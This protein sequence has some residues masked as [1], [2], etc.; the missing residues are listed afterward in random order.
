M[1]RDIVG[2]ARSPIARGEDSRAPLSAIERPQGSLA[3]GG[4]IDLRTMVRVLRR[5]KLMLVLVVAVGLAGTQAWIMR[6]TPLYSAD[7]LLMIESRPSSIVTTDSA[8]QDAATG[9]VAVN[10]QIA[11]LRSRSLAA[12]VIEG[13]GLRED[14]EFAPGSEPRT[15]GLPM[16]LLNQALAWVR[17]LLPEQ[18]AASLPT[19]VNEPEETGESRE[20]RIR[21][22]LHDDFLGRL[23]VRSEDQSRLI[24]VS[25]LSADP[26]KAAAITNALLKTY[27]DSQLDAKTEGARQTATWLEARLGE[28]GAT[29]NDLERTV[30]Q[31]RTEAGLFMDDGQNVVPQRLGQLNA[32]LVRT[33]A[34]RA[35]LEARQL[36]IQKF[37]ETGRGLETLPEVISSPAVQSYRGRL[38]QLRGQLSELSD[39]YQDGNR[40]VAAVEAE[41][42]E[43]Q[44][45]IA[46]EMRTVLAG[47]ANELTYTGEQEKA[48]RRQLDEAGE[49]VARLNSASLAIGQLTTQLRANRDLYE[50]LLKRYT[51]TVALRD[52]QQPDARIISEAQVPIAPSFPNTTRALALASVASIAVALLFVIIAE[53]FRNRFDTQG[54]VESHLGTHVISVPDLSRLWSMMAVHPREYIQKEPLSEF[55]SAFQ[56]LRALLAL[57]NGRRM[58]RL[59]LVT[60]TAPGEGKTTVA[61]CLG[62][63]SVSSGQKVVIV[64]CDFL[65]PSVHRMM[66]VGDRTGLSDVL[67]G[68]A[69]LEEALIPVSPSMDIM[70]SGRATAGGIDLLNSTRMVTLLKEL[71]A[72][73]DMIILDSAPV[74]RLSDPLILGGIVQRTLLVTRRDRTTQSDAVQAI[75]QLEEYG[76]HI[77][78][79][80]FNRANVPQARMR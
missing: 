9:A 33:Q 15:L 18:L 26:A 34:Q 3:E 61:V 16:R 2:S 47:V 55:G 22:A 67:S 6:T 42:A 70:A 66:N 37:L 60:S 74:L 5:R 30:Q 68:S 80:V 71:N 10:T 12:Q 78:A 52:N 72:M 20:H 62:I 40:R 45:Q 41:I 54:D 75:H 7:A 19:D 39:R 48:L 27:I 32:E 58:P 49:E 29:V 77:A 56:R 38:V 14:P 79:V 64:D 51:E 4:E 46:L 44:R 13:M 31:R 65:S 50:N 23:T 76:A 11:V 24:S 21:T 59:V 1:I 73:Y 35:T 17:P 57:G 36:R 8:K 69:C 43:L 28:L 63:A 25:F 53:R